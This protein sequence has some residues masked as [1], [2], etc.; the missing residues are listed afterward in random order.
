M[1]EVIMMDDLM[2]LMSLLDYYS[3]GSARMI[4][5]NVDVGVYQ[6]T[7]WTFVM[8]WMFTMDLCT[9][10]HIASSAAKV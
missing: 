6:V 9:S 5:Q 8:A 3:N 1:S 7:A 10:H 2:I 4:C